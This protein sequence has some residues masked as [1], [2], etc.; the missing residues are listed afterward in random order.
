MT[1]PIWQARE[2]VE[3][4][5]RQYERDGM[6][7]IWSLGEIGAL[8]EDPEQ[9]AELSENQRRAALSFVE[10]ELGGDE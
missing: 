1:R 7:R 8:L 3:D 5:I 4:Q 6:T 2:W 9:H 10:R